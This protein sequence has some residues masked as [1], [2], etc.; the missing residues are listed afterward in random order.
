MRFGSVGKWHV[1]GKAGKLGKFKTSELFNVQYSNVIPRDLVSPRNSAT[2]I[3][4][5]ATGTDA[6]VVTRKP[7]SGEDFRWLAS[8]HVPREE[9]SSPVLV[10]A[11]GVV[12]RDLE[13]ELRTLLMEEE[14]VTVCRREEGEREG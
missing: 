14:K 3:P 5:R 10:L 4:S 12:G 6:L 13:L 8:R 1:A 2:S 7:L 9:N 11:F